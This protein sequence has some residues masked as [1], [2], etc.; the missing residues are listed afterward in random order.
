[1]HTATSATNTST[2]NQHAG[3][4]SVIAPHMEA[5]EHLLR[6]PG[7]LANPLLGTALTTLFN[8][9]G[10]RLRP[11]VALLASSFHPVELD[12]RLFLAAALETLHTATLI[13]DDVVDH[14]KLRRGKPTLNAH[15]SDGMTILAGDYLFARAAELVSRTDHVRVI[16]R[17]AQ[18]LMIIVDGELQQGWSIGHGIPTLEEYYARINGKTADMF[19]TAAQTGMMLSGAPANE[20]DA[21]QRYGYYLGMAF[22]IVDDILDFTSDQHALGK[23]A[24]HDL[25]EGIVTL[26]VLLYIENKPADTIAQ[27]EA[28]ATRQAGEEQLDAV[29]TAIRESD[30]PARALE[31]AR[32][33][34]ADARAMLPSFPATA[35]RAALEALT[36]QATERQK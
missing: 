19:A 2:P 7:E 18:M 31:Y 34:A 12:K 14:A 8:S 1:M 24:G 3:P 5:V 13:H 26:P 15:W 33:F 17:F 20:I 35:D 11:A 32:R 6:D 10:K 25:R 27:V 22:Q 21:M 28:V 9:G 16:R 36:I 4:L 23:P 30:A 29:I